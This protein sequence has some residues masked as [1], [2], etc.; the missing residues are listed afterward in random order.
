MSATP[1]HFAHQGLNDRALQ[2]AIGELYLSLCPD[3]QYIAPRLAWP[4]RTNTPT[5]DVLRVGFISL[6]FYDHS[7][8]KILLE[9]LYS[10]HASS[11]SPNS[12]VRLQV[13]VFFV[14]AQL[15]ATL[16][17][18][19]VERSGGYSPGTIGAL[20][21]EAVLASDL[22]RL[23]EEQFGGRRDQVTQA[24][25]SAFGRER[26]VRL[27]QDISFV[28]SVVGSARYD[29]DVL[30]FTDVG[31][32]F[33]SYVLS[34]SRLATYQVCSPPSTCT[35]NRGR[36][37]RVPGGMVGSPHHHRLASH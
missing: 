12:A 18:G 20:N 21:H 36:F 10:L 17:I 29:L 8:G 22:T 32:D 13:T 30:V 15:S 28:R 9:T 14:D 37:S 27:F 24:F 1:F 26:Y 35:V 34:H 33:T 23:H 5:E 4:P 25:A 2:S 6:N 11:S 31:L 16:F 19:H 3:L 7:I